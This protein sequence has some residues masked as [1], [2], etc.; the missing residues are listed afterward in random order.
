MAWNFFYYFKRV[1]DRWIKDTCRE[2]ARS[3]KT[4]ALTKS[5]NMDIWVVSTSNQLFI[6]GS[7]TETKFSNKVI[8]D[9]TPF[10]VMVHF[11]LTTLF[12]LTLASDMAVLYWSAFSILVLSTR[13]RYSSFLKRVFVFQKMC[14]KVKLL[15]SFKIFTDCHIKTCRS[16]KRT[17]IFKI[18]SAV[19]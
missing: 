17:A 8:T 10:F 12:V 2:K 7:E 6:R 19:F 16:L 4:P 18:P 3:N 14:F 15:R 5:M 9:K 13:K 1:N 11:V